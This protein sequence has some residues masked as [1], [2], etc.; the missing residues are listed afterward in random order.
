M[1]CK[2]YS[3]LVFNSIF[4]S[5]IVEEILGSDMNCM[6][7]KGW[8]MAVTMLRLL[9]VFRSYLQPLRNLTL[10]KLCI[11]IESSNKFWGSEDNHGNN[12]KHSNQDLGV[13]RYLR[14]CSL[15]QDKKVS[16]FL[17]YSRY[18][19]KLSGICN[20]LILS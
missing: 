5:C 12:T 20:S 14:F 13:P 17:M 10:F 16:S 1:V 19:A 18:K 7:F 4:F 11:H 9:N 15:H 2:D 6:D 3:P 8:E